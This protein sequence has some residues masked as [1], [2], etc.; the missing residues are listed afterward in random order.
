MT[1]PSSQQRY[2]KFI[3]GLS[4]L[5]SS[6]T[7]DD[8]MRFRHLARHGFADLVPVIEGCIK[9]IGR[10]KMPPET[11]LRSA[12]MPQR[13]SSE[14][15]FDLLRSKKH[16]PTNSR[17]AEFATR[18][19]PGITRKRY[20]KMSRAD[21]AGQIIEYIESFPARKRERLESLIRDAIKSPDRQAGEQQESFFSKWEKVIKG[22]EY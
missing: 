2:F 19:L 3:S 5:L 18:I 22:L 11:A 10:R 4:D 8:L 1:E 13:S 12:E 17:L 9:M 16:F 6:V 20:D 14:H 7:R 21:I 15:L